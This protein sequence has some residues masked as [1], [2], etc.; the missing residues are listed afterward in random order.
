LDNKK[1]A[2]NRAQGSRSIA[3]NTNRQGDANVT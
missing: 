2:L 3:N 1:E